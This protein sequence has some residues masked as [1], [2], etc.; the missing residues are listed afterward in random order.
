MTDPPEVIPF[1]TRAIEGVVHRGSPFPVWETAERLSAAIERAGA[2]IF[3]SID[4]AAE[5]QAVGLTLR[6]TRLLIFGSPAAGTAVMESAPV[7]ALDLPLKILVWAD[8]EERVWMSYLSGEW[9]A[10]RHGLAEE[11]A[12]RLSAPEAI[13][14]RV[15]GI[16]GPSAADG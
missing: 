7:A 16:G 10:K 12:P 3:A 1:G 2:K 4:Q 14:N 15:G 11:L 8:A 6:A 5:A 9:L 13:V